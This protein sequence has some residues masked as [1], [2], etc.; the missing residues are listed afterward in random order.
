MKLEPKTRMPKATCPSCRASVDGATGVTGAAKP[1]A[2][3]ITVCIFCAS[4][5]EFDANMQLRPF[6]VATLPADERAQIEK[7]CA[8]IRK[9]CAS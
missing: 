8:A 2:G 5:A 4:V 9:T 3:D 1:C 6:D 7:L